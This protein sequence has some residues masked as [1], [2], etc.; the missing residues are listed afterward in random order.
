[1]AISPEIF[2][3]A[4]RAS[5]NNRRMMEG[6]EYRKKIEAGLHYTVDSPEVQRMRDRIEAEYQARMAAEQGVI[7]GDASF[8]ASPAK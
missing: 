7:N 2:E 3:W 6:E 8:L 4:Q 5:E 1:M